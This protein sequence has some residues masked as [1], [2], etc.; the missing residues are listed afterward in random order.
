MDFCSTILAPAALAMA[1]QPGVKNAVP[2]DREPAT[3]EDGTGEPA[4]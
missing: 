1:P 2:C 3:E 4:R